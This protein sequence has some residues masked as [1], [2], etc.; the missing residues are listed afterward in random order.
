MPFVTEHFVQSRTEDFEQHS[1]GQSFK[2]VSVHQNTFKPVWE[3][4]PT[5]SEVHHCRLYREG[6]KAPH[7]VLRTVPTFATV[8]TFRASGDTQFPYG[9]CLLTQGYFCVA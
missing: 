9:S 8:H 1:S 2:V 3:V 5:S 7:P 4:L 6:S